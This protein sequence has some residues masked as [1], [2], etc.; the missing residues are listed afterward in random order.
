M[1]FVYSSHTQDLIYKSKDGCLVTAR[2]VQEWFYFEYF[3]LPHFK[4][5]IYMYI[6]MY[7][8]IFFIYFRCYFLILRLLLLMYYYISTV[9]CL[10][11]WISLTIYAILKALITTNNQGTMHLWIFFSYVLFKMYICMT[12]SNKI[13]NNHGKLMFWIIN[14]MYGGMRYPKLNSLVKKGSRFQT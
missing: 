8:S 5:A 9:T 14:S 2:D 13:Y 3:H 6:S 1:Y 11:T 7:R 12:F 10:P 4:C